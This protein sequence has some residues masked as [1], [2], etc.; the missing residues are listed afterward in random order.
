MQIIKNKARDNKLIQLDKYYD[1]SDV[2]IFDIETTGFAAASTKLYLIGC[3]YYEGDDIYIIQW[4]NDDGKSEADIIKAFFELISSYKYL[5]HYNGDGFDIPYIN[6]KIDEF[7]LDFSFDNI[8]SVDLYKLIRPYKD[9]LHLDNLK[10]KSIERFLDLNRLDKYSGGDL[11]K[12]YKEYLIKPDDKKEQLLL[13]HNYEDI[14]GLIYN[15]CM[16]A[17]TKLHDGI[18][19][20]SSMKV[21]KNKLL[22]SLTLDYDLPKRISFSK[23]DIIVTGYQ[24]EATIT[25]PIVETTLKFFFKDYKE[26]YFI[27]SEDRAIHKSVATYIDKN[28]RLKAN[29]ENCYV[30]QS[31]YFITQ[32]DADI[33][34]GFKEN[35]NDKTSYIEL[36]DTFLQDMNK[37]TEYAK[38]IISRLI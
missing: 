36:V 5:L 15:F 28:S 27:P 31:G 16:L 12:I 10:L 9:A 11:I 7:K 19:T 29:K 25:V 20:V 22:F 26:Y 37:I 18:F 1:K 3:G 21:R 23:Y 30:K 38:Q 14:E 6:N 35:Y 17:Y 34:T 4:F 8:E 24:N 32:L 2:I 13:Q 33:I